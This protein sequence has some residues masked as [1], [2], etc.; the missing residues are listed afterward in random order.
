MRILMVVPFNPYKFVGG[1]E[2]A[3]VKVSEELKKMGNEVNIAYFEGEGKIS[4]SVSRAEIVRRFGEPDVVHVHNL[5]YPKTILFGM[6]MSRFYKVVVSPHF[7]GTGR[8]KWLWPL[9]L[10]LVRAWIKKVKVHAVSEY[11]ASLIKKYL[12]VEPEVIPHGIDE[13]VFDYS[14]EPEDYVLYSGRIEEYKRIEKLGEVVK[15]LNEMGIKVRLLVQ[16]EGPY[17]E[18]LRRKLEELGIDFEM[19]GFVEREEYLKTLS[20]AKLFGNLSL[21]EAYSIASAEALAM[22]VPS[23]LSLPWGQH[24]RHCPSAILSSPEESAQN[25]ARRVAKFLETYT[26]S[27]CPF[28]PWSSVARE[29]LERLYSR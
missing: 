1:I 7:H 18:T 16:G 13:D 8:R 4:L 17:K 27:K 5:H 15:Y 19:R 14:W 10:K 29:Y 20:H 22:G 21:L 11:E 25:I 9:W 26:L 28:K 2:H 12:G 6:R 23:L 24:F 3:V